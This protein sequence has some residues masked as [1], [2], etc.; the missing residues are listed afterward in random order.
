MKEK[1][2]C[3]NCGIILQQGIMAIITQQKTYE[4]VDGIYCEKCA[5]KRVESKRK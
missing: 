4:F 5:K 2:Y 3:A 1:I